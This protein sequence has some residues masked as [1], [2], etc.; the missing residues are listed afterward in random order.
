MI[1]KSDK[2][3]GLV[4]V[5]LTPLNSKIGSKRVQQSSTKVHR[6]SYEAFFIFEFVG[7]S[8]NFRWTLLNLQRVQRTSNELPPKPKI[9]TLIEINDFN[10]N[11]IDSVE[12]TITGSLNSRLNSVEP[13]SGS[14]EVQLTPQFNRVQW[15]STEFKGVQRI[16]I[17]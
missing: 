15:S 16:F 5:H 3:Y 2:C 13:I 17:L 6:T 12:N 9:L 4:G 7:S 14:S 8:L 10:L 1:E 11:S